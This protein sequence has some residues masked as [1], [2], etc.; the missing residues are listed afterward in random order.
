MLKVGG[1]RDLGEEPVAADDGGELGL[2]HHERDLAMVL[3]VLGQVH[4]GHAA[5]AE[6]AL[7]QVAV[8]Q[9]RR[10]A[11]GDVVHWRACVICC[12]NPW[13]HPVQIMISP[14]ACP[15]VRATR[16][17]RPSGVTSYFAPA[18]FASGP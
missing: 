3:E 18:A 16:N 7:D 8:G 4:R 17:R 13:S 10:Q 11:A 2:E 6:L 15:I 1:R 14:F 12:F 9:G 5:R